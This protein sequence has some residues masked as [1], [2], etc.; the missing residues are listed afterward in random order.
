MANKNTIVEVSSEELGGFKDQN[1]KEILIKALK[2]QI[3][4]IS[5]EKIDGTIRD[6]SC[7]LMESKIP[8]EKKPKTEN[9]KQNVTVLPVFD[10]EKES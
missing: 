6:M 7:T 5:F 8:T 4:E 10:T 3:V 1:S 2:T 9:S